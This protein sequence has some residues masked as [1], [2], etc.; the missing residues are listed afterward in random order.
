[1]RCSSANLRLRRDRALRFDLLK[2]LLVDDN[3]HIRVLLSQILRAIDV[4]HIHEAGD[5]AEAL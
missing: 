5:G 1:M 4:R 3:P 2:I